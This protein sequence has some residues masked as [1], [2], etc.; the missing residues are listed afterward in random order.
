[1]CGQRRPAAAGEHAAADSDTVEFE[2]L[3][4]SASAL[5]RAWRCVA[6][7]T[8]DFNVGSRT[9]KRVSF[10]CSAKKKE[11]KEKAAPLPLESCAPSGLARVSEGASCPSARGSLPRP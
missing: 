10:F 7:A 8:A 1:G 6:G 4:N 5:G 11:T 2:G 9:D 3:S